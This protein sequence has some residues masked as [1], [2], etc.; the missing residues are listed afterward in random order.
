MGPGGF[1]WG[2]MGPAGR[3]DGMPAWGAPLPPKID[4]KTLLTISSMFM[5]SIPC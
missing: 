2:I 4:F 3:R 1:I 5:L